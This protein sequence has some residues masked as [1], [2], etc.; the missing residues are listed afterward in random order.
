LSYI[1]PD[2]DI[3]S[4]ISQNKRSQRKIEKDLAA[5]C[6]NFEMRET[7]HRRVLPKG[8]QPPVLRKTVVE[9]LRMASGLCKK[10]GHPKEY[11]W[12]KLKANIDRKN[13]LRSGKG[14]AHKSYVERKDVLSFIFQL[15]EEKLRIENGGPQ[16]SGTVGN[17][18]GAAPAQATP[19]IEPLH[20]EEEGSQ[21][22]DSEEEEEDKGGD[23][24][25]DE[26]EDVGKGDGKGGERAGND[27]DSE[28]DEESEE[29]WDGGVAVVLAKGKP[30]PK[31]TYRSASIIHDEEEDE[32][33]DEQVTVTVQASRPVESASGD[34]AKTGEDD[35]TSEKDGE[36]EDGAS[37][38]DGEDDA[39]SEKDGDGDDASE[40][41]G[42][43]DGTDDEEDG[44]SEREGEAQ[45]TAQEEHSEAGAKEGAGA[46]WWTTTPVLKSDSRA[47]SAT[48]GEESEADATM[49]DVDPSFWDEALKSG[50]QDAATYVLAK[51]TQAASIRKTKKNRVVTD[52]DVE[53]ETMNSTPAAQAGD[54]RTLPAEYG[55]EEDMQ[56]SSPKRARLGTPSEVVALKEA[57]VPMA[58]EV[59][60]ALRC[61]Q[62]L[63]Q[64]D[65]AKAVG[66]GIRFLEAGRGNERERKEIMQHMRKNWDE[67]V[68]PKVAETEGWDGDDEPE[69]VEAVQ[70]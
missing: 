50:S 26:D 48:A 38:K 10:L 44:T 1:D 57:P 17:R 33:E 4:M 14:Y 45:G 41:D 15:E 27:V 59:K 6:A 20:R 52:S 29:E 35:A 22:G 49:D 8:L 25:E 2:N 63:R 34:G 56:G 37:E 47:K 28:E 13:E 66:M 5:F 64:E 65:G 68:K 9:Q 3:G 61:A 21:D 39:T 43:E 51:E 67:K 53:E 16:G 19:R 46:D 7:D 69:V 40:K 32:S 12:K 62:I 54:K 58:Q 30:A 11:A 42:E 24:D 60:D 55:D 36:E 18:A 23:E 31:K 70:A